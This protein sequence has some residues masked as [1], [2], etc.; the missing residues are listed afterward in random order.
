VRPLNVSMLSVGHL[1]V[2]KGKVMAMALWVVTDTDEFHGA[3]VE[4]EDARR[5]EELARVANAGIGI[6]PVKTTKVNYVVVNRG[7][8]SYS[9]ES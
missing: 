3:I 1:A 9:R 4:A 5:A 8:I 7:V 2:H 6:R